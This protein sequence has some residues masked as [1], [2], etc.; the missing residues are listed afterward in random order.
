[1][2]M[3]EEQKIPAERT[4]R[5]SISLRLSQ[6]ELLVVARRRALYL[7]NDPVATAEAALGVGDPW[8]SEEALELAGEH[9]VT[10]H[11]RFPLAPGQPPS[12]LSLTLGVEGDLWTFSAIT[13][14]SGVDL[15]RHFAQ[16]GVPGT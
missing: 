7:G 14:M 15:L 6:Q 3:L 4:T 1:M 5:S 2:R 10:V 11:G 13:T 8:Y 12:P 16:E 9:A